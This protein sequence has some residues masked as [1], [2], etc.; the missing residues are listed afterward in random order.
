LLALFGSSGPFPFI[1]GLVMVFFEC[2]PLGTLLQEILAKQ[3][4]LQYVLSIRMPLK[5]SLPNLLE[6]LYLFK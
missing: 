6:P 1:V 2:S 4:S 3:K 5:I